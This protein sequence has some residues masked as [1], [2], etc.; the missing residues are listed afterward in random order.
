ML[1]KDAMVVN[2]SPELAK[3]AH[4]ALMLLYAYLPHPLLLLLLLPF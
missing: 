1:Y 4:P 3:D 2:S